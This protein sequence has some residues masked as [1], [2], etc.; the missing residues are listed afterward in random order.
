MS[1]GSGLWSSPS[2]HREPGWASLPRCAGGG[3][4]SFNINYS[5]VGEGE[6]LSLCTWRLV[7]PGGLHLLVTWRLVGMG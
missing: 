7:N 3:K 4:G 1:V 5:R 6:S 2:Q